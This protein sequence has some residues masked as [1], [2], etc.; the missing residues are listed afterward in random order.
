M[1]SGVRTNDW[2]DFNKVNR[3]IQKFINYKNEQRINELE[4]KVRSLRTSTMRF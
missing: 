1:E 4:N 2:F 3:I